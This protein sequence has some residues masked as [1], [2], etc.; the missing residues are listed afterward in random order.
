MGQCGE[1]EA[2]Y[3]FFLLLPFD[4]QFVYLHISMGTVK[5]AT[6]CKA[7]FLLYSCLLGCLNGNDNVTER[8]TF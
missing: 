2:L 4:L 1:V 3:P 8:W 6:T 7:T 5:W